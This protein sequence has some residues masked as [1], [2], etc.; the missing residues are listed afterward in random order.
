LDQFPKTQGRRL[1]GKKG[2]GEGIP[3]A[4][5]VAFY[6]KKGNRG[7]PAVYPAT[8]IQKGGKRKKREEIRKQIYFSFLPL[9][10][11]VKERGWKTTPSW[12]E[13]EEKK[14][15]R[16]KRSLQDLWWWKGE[17]TTLGVHAWPAK[18]RN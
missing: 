14:E 9:G 18:E 11:G 16:E 1:L 7:E 17:K 12:K 5:L 8:K 13:E 15:K 4:C 2:G 6:R 3:G 10:H